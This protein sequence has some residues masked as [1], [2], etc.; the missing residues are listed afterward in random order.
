MMTM[1]VI[2]IHVFGHMETLI[3]SSFGLIFVFFLSDFSNI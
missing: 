3:N 1:I 2:T